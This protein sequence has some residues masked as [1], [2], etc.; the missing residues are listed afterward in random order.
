MLKYGEFERLIIFDRMD[1]HFVGDE[2]LNF[3]KRLFLRYLH[4]TFLINVHLDKDTPGVYGIIKTAKK[5]KKVPFN[6]ELTLQQSMFDAK[7]AIV[8]FEDN[9][10]SKKNKILNDPGN[11][12]WLKID[13]CDFK[14]QSF[15]IFLMLQDMFTLK[16]TRIEVFMMLHAQHDKLIAQEEN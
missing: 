10:N 16:N 3:N 11:Y 15:F 2:D 6:V 12:N 8:V 7:N 9:V 14:R 13:F 5:P 1:H 4:L